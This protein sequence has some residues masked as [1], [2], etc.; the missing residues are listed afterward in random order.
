MSDD[1]AEGDG[2]VGCVIGLVVV[3]LIVAGLISLAAIVDPFSLM[4]PVGEVWAD[5][6]GDCD[7]ADRFPGFWLHV[8]VNLAYTVA[9]LTLTVVF[10]G[11][12]WRLREARA[13]RFNDAID[14]E[15]LR[16]AQ[17]VCAGAGVALA[18][19]ALAPIVVAVV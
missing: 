9:A 19:L 17:Q 8:V 5:C 15:D 13:G 11:A 12:V 16:E 14:P 6:E 2:C 10:A 1:A 7:L 18:V 4:P 3:G